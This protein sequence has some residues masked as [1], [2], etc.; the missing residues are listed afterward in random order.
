MTDF[1]ELHSLQ[2]VKPQKNVD[3]PQKLGINAKN[4]RKEKIHFGIALIPKK[5]FFRNCT[6]FNFGIALIFNSELRSFQ[7]HF[8]PFITKRFRRLLKVYIKVIKSFFLLKRK[9]WKKYLLQKKKKKRKI[10]Q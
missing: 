3:N 6:H 8:K 2:N 10:N 5:R 4:N 7:K 1:S 9:L